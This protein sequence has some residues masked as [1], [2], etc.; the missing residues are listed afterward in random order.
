MIASRTK[1]GPIDWLRAERRRRRS[2][3]GHQGKPDFEQLVGRDGWLRLAPDIRAR[4][5]EKPKPGSPI[6]YSGIMRRVDCSW[7]GLLLGHFCRLLGTPFAPFR[8]RD[9]PVA[10]V[11]R[12]DPD[13][14]A[15]IWEREYRYPDHP[16]VVVR[17]VKRTAPDGGLLECVGCGFGMR[18]AVYEADAALHFLSRR[19][20]WSVGRRQ[21]ALPDLL[22]PGVAHVIHEDLGQGRFRFVMTI[23][24]TL[25]GTLFYQEGVFQREGATP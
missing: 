13:D 22:S 24:N 4:F 23:R 20:F 17:S 25:L 19:Y 10:I 7:A 6:C 16:P 3:E 12:A 21:F 1:Q 11:L 15:I 5:T 14:G 8:G 2:P 18:L 9:V